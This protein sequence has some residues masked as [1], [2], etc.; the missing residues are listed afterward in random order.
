M[1]NYDTFEDEK[2]NK[3]KEKDAKK[4]KNINKNSKNSKIS[5]NFRKIRSGLNSTNK[6]KSSKINFY[7]R[8]KENIYKKEIDSEN[9]KIKSIS[10][11]NTIDKMKILDKSPFKKIKK[12]KN[13]FL[14][15]QNLSNEYSH[16]YNTTR[17]R[18]SNQEFIKYYNSVE[19]KQFI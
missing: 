18:A 9:S 13:K 8:K 12:T 1:S 19:K 17:L 3:I 2:R 15:K 6:T 16:T 11:L 7:D 4:G 10:V 5:Q 14:K